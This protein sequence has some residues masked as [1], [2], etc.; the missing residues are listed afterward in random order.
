MQQKPKPFV[1]PMLLIATILTALGW[2][3]A[4]YGGWPLTLISPSDSLA[5]GRSGPPGPADD[6]LPET[7]TPRDNR[8]LQGSAIF[9]M[10]VMMSPQ[11]RVTMFNQ[12]VVGSYDNG[13]A[14]VL[15]VVRAPK[16][17][18]Y[19]VNCVTTGFGAKASLT[20]V[21]QPPVNVTSWDYR[22]R[23]QGM[24]L[25][26]ALVELKAGQHFFFWRLEDVNVSVEFLETHILKA[27]L[28]G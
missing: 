18:W 7:L 5:M 14:R 10:G 16:D 27:K 4:H 24:H 2:L 8:S 21:A 23:P 11:S 28:E 3:G 20:T 13:P 26:P 1:L 12:T 25:Y 9:F 22:N 17:G 6:S 15:I 19:I